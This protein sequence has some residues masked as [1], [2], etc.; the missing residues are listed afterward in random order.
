MTVNSGVVTQLNIIPQEE[1]RN[2]VLGSSLVGQWLGFRV[3]TAGAQVH[4]LAGEL[5]SHLLRV[6]AKKK[7]KK[8]QNVV[9]E[10]HKHSVEWKK[11]DTT[12]EC[13]PLIPFV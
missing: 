4:S 13:L 9:N 11:L 8:I 3:F 5:R 12:K 10:L 1:W 2:N 6:A 7:K